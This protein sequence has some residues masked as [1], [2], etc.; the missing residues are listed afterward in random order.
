M[1]T[2][3]LSPISPESPS[4]MLTSVTPTLD[5]GPSR[6]SSGTVGAPLTDLDQE[7][8]LEKTLLTNSSRGTL[9]AGEPNNGQDFSRTKKPPPLHAGADWKVVLHLPEIE[10]WLRATSDRVTQLTH[11][12]SQDADNRHVDVHLM[13]LKDVCEDIS[14]HVEQI[15]ALLETEFSLK[16]LSYSVNIIVDIR[17]VQLL[18]HQLRVSV[19]VLK[20]RLLQGLQDS[21]GNYTRQTD[22]LQAFSQDQHQTRLDALTEVDDCGQLTIRCS[23]DY[24]SLDCGI[25]AFELSVCSPSDE[26]EVCSVE[27][28]P[29]DSHIQDSNQKPPV[30]EEGEG[31]DPP[32]PELPVLSASSNQ[33]HSSSV[34]PTVQCGMP[35]QGESSKR[36]LQG[37][38]HNTDT[39]PTHPSLPKR[40]ALLINQEAAD[41]YGDA[42]KP[43]CDAQIHE[44]SRST[45]SLVEPPDRSKFW[46]ELDSVYSQNVSQSCESLQMIERGSTRRSASSTQRARSGGCGHRRLPHRSSGVRPSK[47]PLAVQSSMSQE[48]GSSQIQQRQKEA[49]LRSKGDSESSSPSPMKEQLLSS[50]TEASREESEPQLHPSKATV[51]IVKQRGEEAQVPASDRQHWYGSE[52]FLAL[53]AQ[54]HKTE[55][56]TLKLE[57]LTKSIPHVDLQDVDDWELTELNTDWDVGESG[58]N[59]SGDDAPSP[60]QHPYRRKLVSRFSPTSSSDIAPSLDE[61]LESGPFSDLQSDEDE[62]RRSGDPCLQRTAPLVDGRGCVAL[63]QQLLEDIQSQ[64]KDPDVWIKIEGFVQK[65]DGF[66]SWLHE[67]LGSTENWTQPRQ[68]LES[69]K[70]YLD[71]HLSFKL[72][73]DSH[74]ALKLSIME[75]GRALLGVLTSH[76]S[77]LKDILH[78]VSSQWDQLQ[79]QIR[80]QHGWMLRTLRCIQARLF[81]TNQSQ[82]VLTPLWD[83]SANPRRSCSA[84]GQEMDLI[85]SQFKVQRD[86]LERMAIKLSSLQYPPPPNSRHNSQETRSTSLQEFESEYQELWD[87]LMDLDAM[88]TDSHHLLM[89]EDQRL[90]LFKSS[91]CDMMMM[92]GRRTGLLSRAAALRRTG[93]TLPPNLHVRIHKLTQT[94]KQLE[95]VLSEHSGPRSFERKQT[96]NVNPLLAGGGGVPAEELPSVLSPLTTS[97]LE[98]LEARI[99]ELKAW[100]RDTELLIFNS[101]QKQDQNVSEQLQSFKCLSSEIR[102]RRRGVSSVL[103]LCQKLLL[104]SQAGPMAEVGP[105]AEQHQEALQLL[106]INLQRRWEAIVMQ[107]LQWQNRLRRKLGEQQV[108]GNFLEPGLLDLHHISP[109]TAG[110]VPPASDDSWEWDET[111]MTIGEADLHGAPEPDLTHDL[112]TRSHP[113]SDYSKNPDS[114]APNSRA[115]PADNKKVYQVYSLHN[116][117]LYQQPQFPLPPSLLHQTKAGKRKHQV[118][119]KSFS[120][121]SSF[122]SIESLPDLLGGLMPSS[123]QQEAHGG[124]RRSGQSENSRRSDCESGIVSDT[125]DT[126]TLTTNSE[127]QGKEEDEG[128]EEEVRKDASLSTDRQRSETG[129]TEN[130]WRVN[131]QRGNEEEKRRRNRKRGGNA[132]E[133]LINGYG[134]LTPPDSDSDLEGLDVGS[135]FIR[136]SAGR[137]LPSEAPGSPI[138]HQKSPVLSS[139]ESLLGLSVELFPSREALHRSASLESCLVSCY[140]EEAEEGGSFSCI[141]DLQGGGATREPRSVENTYGG[142]SSGELS[143]RTLDLLKRLENIQN[144]LGAKM[145]RSVSDMTLRTSSSENRRLSASPRV[146]RSPVS[147]IQESSAATSLTELSS[148]ED[149]SL[150]SED[151]NR[152]RTP[153]QLFLHPN[154]AA[155]RD[156][157]RSPNNNRGGDEADA[158]SLSMVVNVSCT[159]TDEEEED[160]DLLS[161]S[162]LTLTEEELGVRDEENRS[163]EKLSGASS[164]NDID[165]EDEEEDMEG[166]YMLGFE[167]MKKELQ[168]WIRSPRSCASSR[169]EAVLWD[170]L[171]CGGMMSSALA[172]S[173][174]PKEQPSNPTAPKL[175]E[176]RSKAEQAPTKARQEEEVKNGRSTARSFV[177]QFVDDVEN[178]NV[179]PSALKGKDEDELLREE[180]S[181]FI[182]KGE[183]QQELYLQPPRASSTHMCLSPSC[184]LL[185]FPSKRASSLVGQLRGELPCHSVCT[186]SPPSLS[187]VEDSR[188]HRGSHPS[189][190]GGRKA[191]TIQEKFKFSSIVTEEAKKEVRAKGSSLPPKKWASCC[192]HR[193]PPPHPV[194]D[195]KKENERDFV[196]EIIDMTAVALKRKENPTEEPDRSPTSR[197]DP[198]QSPASA[199]QIRE[200]VLELSHRPLHL[201]K[202]D[203]YSYLSLSSHDSDCGEVSQCAE[204]RSSTPPPYSVPAPAPPTTGQFTSTKR[205]NSAGSSAESSESPPPCLPF[206]AGGSRA[207]DQPEDPLSPGSCL[208]PSPDIRDEETLFPACTEEVYLGPPLCYSMLLS[209]R[210]SFLQRP[211][212]DLV[213]RH[214]VFLSSA[215]DCLQ[216][217]GYKFSSPPPLPPTSSGLEEEQRD[218]EQRDS[219]FVGC[220]LLLE[221]SVSGLSPS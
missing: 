83:S 28:M 112:P 72:S 4:P 61:S 66:I 200:K 145:T 73:V 197:A 121:D 44:L 105:D 74:G 189:S 155:N 5:L 117:E 107:A 36:I 192:R 32:Q 179:E 103:K 174:L 110:P 111:D 115:F 89:S 78:M 188:P 156:S 13:Q 168:S 70:A 39:S 169:T 213:P 210:P 219:T 144:P 50:D 67:A 57:S 91:H 193:S 65:L 1:T 182:K 221:P 49:R 30:N 209:K 40:A 173:S 204:D 138:H 198:D 7:G 114:A 69:L 79:R 130:G 159:C 21:N 124:G 88:V 68:D 51:W 216:D 92:E 166:C 129:V 132:V 85:S 101:C 116:V 162:T 119:L 123:P 161:S 20:E 128:E 11:S 153:Q 58:D 199:A 180:S 163:E 95:K 84:E 77:A 154:M 38:S 208:P 23:Q 170:E 218:E 82:E 134:I 196:M 141:G 150:G 45:P 195:S 175:M 8:S 186:S 17:T 43:L 41:S 46:L 206:G 18:W 142:P 176:S 48:E 75:E 93:A 165:E 187:P 148:N 152:V 181:V 33:N 212:V 184:E 56:L 35:N 86:A 191:I 100:L 99:K 137:C 63:V 178:G 108:S 143:Q 151:F 81:Y 9:T 80:R 214:C 42:A 190:D 167:Y 98:Q 34:L 64:N 135:S 131:R 201:R 60:L 106:S 94:W 183:C 16:L 217:P 120:K 54:L 10:K 147:G 2:V 62:G 15:H 127:S 171:Q 203:F 26:P 22:I 12:A 27:P 158:A 14:D 146:R 3:A 97:L 149:C 211:G 25:T 139:L 71:T 220:S 59:L 31:T 133:I 126:E 29:E 104:Q 140:R 53:P 47:G 177:S 160:S 215:S 125:G 205:Y 109:V 157:Y 136:S 6:S 122:S 194:Q 185:P 164:G 102:A 207:V 113:P 24:F 87:W 55:M 96:L 52:E 90:H 172:S 202:G 37:G 76:H 118:L 19:L